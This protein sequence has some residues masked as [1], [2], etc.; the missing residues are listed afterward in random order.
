MLR[1]DVLFEESIETMRSTMSEDECRAVCQFS[2]INSML[3]D[4]HAQCTEDQRNHHRLLSCSRKIAA[5]SHAFAPYFDIINIFVQI[6]PQWLAWFWG[7][8]RLVFKVELLGCRCAA[9]VLVH[10]LTVDSWVVTMSSS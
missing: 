2:D 10:S 7:S 1:P 8:I 9:S 6:K 5:F 3:A 4:M